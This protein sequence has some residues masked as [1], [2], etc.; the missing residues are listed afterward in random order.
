[1]KQRKSM[2]LQL[3]LLNACS[4]YGRILNMYDKVLNM[5]GLH[6]VLNMP[7]NDWICLNR[8]RICLNMSAFTIIDRILNMFHTMQSVRSLCKLWVLIERLAYSE[9]CQ[10][11]EI[12]RFGKIIIVFNCFCKTLY[13]KYLWGF[14]M[15]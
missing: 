5:L 9:P 8:L 2:L 4:E 14:W 3:S 10:R 13:L 15:C 11:P 7:K 6:R 1:M 12:E